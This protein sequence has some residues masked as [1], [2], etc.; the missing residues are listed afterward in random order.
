MDSIRSQKGTSTSEEDYGLGPDD[1]S[2]DP[3]RIRDRLVELRNL[4]QNA[5][6]AA[7][8]GDMVQTELEEF[9]VKAS[10]TLSELENQVFE[11]REFTQEFD[12]YE[13]EEDMWGNEDEADMY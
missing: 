3:E 2:P 8:K 6:S 7:L 4:I 5:V 10:A 13:A 1:S 12:I 9:F 11:M